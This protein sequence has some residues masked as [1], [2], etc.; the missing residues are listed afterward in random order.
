MGKKA[1][2]LPRVAGGHL[3]GWDDVPH[4]GVEASR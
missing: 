4:S 1:E 3:E 2:R